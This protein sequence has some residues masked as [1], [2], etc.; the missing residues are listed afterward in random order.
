MKQIGII[1]VV[2]L[3]IHI[4]V[5]QEKTV[6]FW[7]ASWSMQQRNINKEIEYLN[8]YY[9]ENPNTKTTLVVFNY[10]IKEEVNFKIENG[11]WDL[12]KEKLKSIV[13]DGAT[14]FNP[15]SN[16]SGYKN[17]LL[18]SD[19]FQN[20]S[21]TKPIG[22]AENLYIINSCENVNKEDSKLLADM[23]NGKYINLN[24][25]SNTLINNELDSQ[26]SNDV[27]P[28]S[29]QL[30]EVIVND[31]IESLNKE[32]NDT[33][34]ET[35]KKDATGYAVQS[36]DGDKIDPSY[37]TLSSAVLGKFSGIKI[38]GGSNVGPQK[39]D[40][41]KFYTRGG[42]FSMTQNNYGLI[43]LDGVPLRRSSSVSGETVSTDFINPAN[44]ADITVLKGLAATN[45]YGSEGVNGVILI[46]SKSTSFNSKENR[47][48][49]ALL[50]NNTYDGRIKIKKSV[51]LTPYLKELKTNKNVADAYKKYLDQRDR[52]KD[53]PQYFIDVYDFFKATNPKIAYQILSNI[54]EYEEVE[55]SELKSLLFTLSQSTNKDM[56][57]EVSKRLLELYPNRI[58]SY[59]DMA[60]AYMGLGEYQKA[61]DLL[62]ENY[63]E[64]VD[65]NIESTIY[66]KIVRDEIKKWVENTFCKEKGLAEAG[67]LERF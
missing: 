66:A 34:T 4:V 30:E 25:T 40:L 37:T 47:K 5:A 42:K 29:T 28:N 11:N 20:I 36:L 32:G 51:K 22:T 14:S 39:S 8:Q 58:E 54:M 52:Y 3:C 50:T 33:N 2:F 48:N 57:Y 17:A 61:L 13:Y 21:R 43:V 19:G 18:F 62:V 63:N 59:Y 31:K 10:S 38:D 27:Y 60:I 1:I 12:L 65:K 7:D 46:T 9:I 67:R 15:L 49:T 45:I 16:Y 44:I 41:S 64:I 26:N 23:N 35:N 56:F 53:N 55:L 24:K 6:I